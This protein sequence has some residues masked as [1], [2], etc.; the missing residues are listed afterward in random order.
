MR[1]ARRVFDEAFKLQV[2][3]MVKEQGDTVDQVCR[4]MTLGKL[5]FVSCRVY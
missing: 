5:L 3:K 1:K 4:G 2:V